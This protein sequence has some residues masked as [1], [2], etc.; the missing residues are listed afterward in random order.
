MCFLNDQCL[1]NI[2]FERIFPDINRFDEMSLMT[3]VI[4]Y[5]IHAVSVPSVFGSLDISGRNTNFYKISFSGYSLFQG[6]PETSLKKL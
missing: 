4:I 3:V 6:L 5:E 2:L 1:K